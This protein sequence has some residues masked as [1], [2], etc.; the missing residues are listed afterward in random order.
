MDKAVSRYYV[1]TTH[2]DCAPDAAANAIIANI[3]SL[4][5]CQVI[6]NGV[7]PSIRYYLRLLENPNTI[8]TAYAAL[9]RT[10]KAIAHEHRTAWK[11]VVEQLGR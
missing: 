3:K 9:L 1:L 5:E 6:A 7:M 8:F 11:E 2:P 4:Y 10:D